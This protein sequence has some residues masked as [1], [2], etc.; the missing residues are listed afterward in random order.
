LLV[1]LES[2]LTQVEQ[3]DLLMSLAIAGRRSSIT[4]QQKINDEG[5]AQTASPFLCPRQ[6][7]FLNLTSHFIFHY[8]KIFQLT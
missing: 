1:G 3:S 2:F 4:I 5:E 6:N 7:Y 8:E